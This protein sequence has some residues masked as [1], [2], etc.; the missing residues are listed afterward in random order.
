MLDPAEVL[1]EVWRAGYVVGDVS[2]EAVVVYAP[3]RWE[4]PR[5]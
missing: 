3:E 1:L 4:P 2:D 5:G